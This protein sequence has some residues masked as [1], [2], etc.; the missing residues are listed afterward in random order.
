MTIW[1]ITE[2]SKH[3]AF[4]LRSACDMTVTSLLG[5]GEWRTK[6]ES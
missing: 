1:H 3:A 4:K 5:C 2:C 6:I